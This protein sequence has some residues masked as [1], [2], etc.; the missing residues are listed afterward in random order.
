MQPAEC[1]PSAR[2]DSLP[3]TAGRVRLVH[4]DRQL[5]AQTTALRWPGDVSSLM[6]VP[7]VYNGQA[8]STI[9]VVSQR[10]KRATDWDV[11]LMRITAD[12]LA[13]VVVQEHVAVSR[14]QS[15]TRALDVSV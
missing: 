13:V 11:A 2:P 6:T 3:L 4:N 8:W 10:P 1:S 14:G 12:R 15:M 9:E 7:V 5:V